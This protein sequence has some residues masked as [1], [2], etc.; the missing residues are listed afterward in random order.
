M[1]FMKNKVNVFCV[2]IDVILALMGNVHNVL[3]TEKYKMI[4]RS[5][6]RDFIS[7]KFNNA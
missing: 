4:V 2:L 6:F 1:D 7:A 5:V 3:R